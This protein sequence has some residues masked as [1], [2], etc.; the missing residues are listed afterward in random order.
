MK[1]RWLFLASL[2]SFTT[3]P[4][5]GQA[6]TSALNLSIEQV[7]RRTHQPTGWLPSIQ[8]GAPAAFRAGYQVAADSLVHHSGR[9]ALRIQSTG[10]TRAENEFGAAS[11][12]VPAAFKGK[13]IKLTGFLKTDQVQNGAA[14]LW[15][16]VDGPEGVL[17]FDN[18]S[19]RPV[20]GTTDWQE[21]SITLPLDEKAQTIYFG[22]LLS[23]TGTLWL[24]DLT[25]TVD[26]KPLAQAP[27]KP[28][29]H[30]KAE[31]D[32]AFRRGSGLVLANRQ[33]SRARSGLGLCEVLP[34]RRGPR[35]LQ[36]RRRAAARAAQGTGQQEPESPQR[37]PRC[38]GYQPR[39]GARVPYL[40]RACPQQRAPATRP[41]LAQ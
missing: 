29:V 25:L 23:T 39:Q 13:V 3:L 5:R 33:P 12:H 1:T 24:D 27:P 7:D 26:D 38:V 2:L 21:Y 9:Y 6:P 14:G 30:Y 8:A 11:Q 16:R 22:G 18:M 37:G 31:Q 10:Q 35:R 20:Q 28:V 32:T 34:P 4:G 17:E 40:P 41:G 19:K 36:P 15:L